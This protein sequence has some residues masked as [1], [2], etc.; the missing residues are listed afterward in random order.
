[1]IRLTFGIAG[2]AKASHNRAVAKHPAGAVSDLMW[3]GSRVY[4]TIRLS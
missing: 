3:D 1:M 2:F 4:Y